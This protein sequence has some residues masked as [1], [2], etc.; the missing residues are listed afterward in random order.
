MNGWVDGRVDEWADGWMDEQGSNAVEKMC[1]Q[2]IDEDQ[3]AA[4]TF[5][6]NIGGSLYV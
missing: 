3:P 5:C 4:D 1:V 6:C 2:Q